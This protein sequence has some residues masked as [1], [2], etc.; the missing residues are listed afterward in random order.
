MAQRRQPGVPHD[1]VEAQT[2]DHVDARY[3]Q[4]VQQILHHS[5]LSDGGFE[6]CELGSLG[7]WELAGLGV[8]ELR[9]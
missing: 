5:I 3:Y 1:Q 7:V 6:S 2:Q 8:W 4:D 9:R